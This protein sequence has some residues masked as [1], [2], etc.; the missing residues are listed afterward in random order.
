MIHGFRF[1]MYNL[2]REVWRLDITDEN[3]NKN[4]NE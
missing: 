1:E 2:T 4:Y 3:Q